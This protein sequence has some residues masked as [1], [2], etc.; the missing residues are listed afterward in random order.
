MKQRKSIFALAADEG[1]G[2]PEARTGAAAETAVKAVR[3]REP[4]V[5]ATKGLACF[6]VA[7][8]H[9]FQGLVM[10]GLMSPAGWW[11]WFN[12]S[13][14]CFHVQ[15]FF[16]CSGYLWQ[17]SGK[18]R[19]GDS[20]L[21]AVGKKAW[22]L[23]VPYSAF[24]V[25]QWALKT[26]LAPWVNSPAG[27][28]FRAL[29]VAPAPPYWY[30]ATLAMLFALFPRAG[31]KR[32]WAW[33]FGVSVLLKAAVSAWGGKSWGFAAHTVAEHA[34]WFVAGM[35]LASWGAGLLRTR[36]A[37]WAAAV[38]AVAFLAGSTGAPAVGGSVRPWTCWGLGILAC[39]AVPVGFSNATR[40][41]PAGAFW[42]W[43]GR[44]ALP[45]FLMHTLC[46]AAVRMVLRTLGLSTL[47]V[48]VPAMFAASFLGPVLLLRLME[49]VRLDGFLDP[50]RWTSRPPPRETRPGN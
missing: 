44:N 19:D 13:I 5:D 46:A 8:G 48:H 12:A 34:F 21:R 50:R 43:L 39:I 16:L 3:P 1:H 29:F 42:N 26:A 28:L 41:S 38:G 32:A 49:R 22:V 37:R 10:A 47:W 31:T 45:V 15:L 18:G 11:K 2:T 23:G 24:I 25:C 9:G 20:H 36:P 40:P 27:S 33:M 7:V 30:L 4:W 6:L 14:Y 35:G 17:R